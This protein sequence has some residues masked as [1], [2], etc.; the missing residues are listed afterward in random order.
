MG[1][2]WPGAARNLNANPTLAPFM[3]QRNAALDLLAWATAN[4]IAPDQFIDLGI[5][6]NS[7]LPRLYRGLFPNR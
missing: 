2:P 7:A 5:E 6:P 3:F 4:E 1:F